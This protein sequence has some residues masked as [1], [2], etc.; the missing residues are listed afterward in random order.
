[1]VAV[2]E[3]VNPFNDHLGEVWEN[4]EVGWMF[5]VL[6]RARRNDRRMFR[7]YELHPP[8]LDRECVDLRFEGEYEWFKLP[9]FCRVA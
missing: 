6:G 3:G 7:G 5:V 8:R 2:E 9:Y 4:T 1:M